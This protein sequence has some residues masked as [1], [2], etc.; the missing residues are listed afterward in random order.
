MTTFVWTARLGALTALLVI[1]RLFYID[2]TGFSVILVLPG[3]LFLINLLA[4]P[5]K[6]AL[7]WSV[8]LGCTAFVI[9]GLIL[10]LAAIGFFDERSSTIFVFKYVGLLTVAQVALVWGAIRTYYSRQRKD[11]EYESPER[12]IKDG[13]ILNGA[14]VGGVILTVLFLVILAA[15]PTFIRSK[16]HRNDAGAIYSLRVL[17]EALAAYRKDHSGQGYPA[18]LTSLQPYSSFNGHRIDPRLLC[19]NPSCIKDGYVFTYSLSNSKPLMAGYSLIARPVR[20]DRTGSKNFYTDESGGIHAASEDRVP[21]ASD[22]PLDYGPL[23]PEE[24]KPLPED[25]D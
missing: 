15:L 21:L 7:A 24:Q 4:L 3:F 14:I 19:S 13:K 5:R 25:L 22:T 11:P 8:V 18:S 20:Y 17:N 2:D 10:L 16:V 1:A 12:K 23:K 6:R 9:C